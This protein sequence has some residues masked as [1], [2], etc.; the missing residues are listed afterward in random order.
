M[1]ALALVTAMAVGSCVDNEVTFFVEHMKVHPSPPNCVSST[2][3]EVAASGYIDL[4]I[5][6]DFSGYFYVTNHSMIREEYDNLRAET[7]GIFIEGMEVYVVAYTGELVGGSE[8]YEYE[9][10]LPPES[11][12]IVPGIVMPAAV[13]A[14]LRNSYECPDPQQWWQSSVAP[15]FSDG[16]LSIDE[17]IELPSAE[18]FDTLYGKVRFLGHTQGGSEVETQEFSFMIEPCCNCMVNWMN[19]LTPCDAFCTEAESNETCSD[20]ASTGG[21]WE[22]EAVDCREIMS[23]SGAVWETTVVDIFGNTSIITETCDDCTGTN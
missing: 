5:A 22:K 10:Y 23:Y 6:K 2:G 8:Y 9:R 11:S 4:S 19:C 20:G 13:V 3:D 14:E 21:D 18:W 1:T 16:V 7:D 12:D 17:A 15:L